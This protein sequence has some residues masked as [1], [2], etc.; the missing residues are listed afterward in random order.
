MIVAKSRRGS[1]FMSVDK[2]GHS[3]ANAEANRIM[4][5]TTQSTRARHNVMSKLLHR[6]QTNNHLQSNTPAFSEFC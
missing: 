6:T 1:F 3:L 4:L 2:V 5:R